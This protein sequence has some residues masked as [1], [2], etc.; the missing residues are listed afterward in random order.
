MSSRF[1]TR[2]CTT[3][4]S[5]SWDLS[6]CIRICACC[7]SLPHHHQRPDCW[8]VLGGVAAVVVSCCQLQIESLLGHPFHLSSTCPFQVS[9]SALACRAAC[10]ALCCCNSECGL[11]SASDMHLHVMHACHTQCVAVL[12]VKNEFIDVII[13]AGFL[14]S[15]R[16]TRCLTVITAPCVRSRPSNFRGRPQVGCLPCAAVVDA[17]AHDMRCC[18]GVRWVQARSP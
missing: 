16:I 18:W 2:L 3:W 1:S 10:G 4:C 6:C 5:H 15:E 14:L 11:A 7:L 8:I 9:I 13:I 17:A 12:T